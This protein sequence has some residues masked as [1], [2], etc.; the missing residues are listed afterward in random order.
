MRLS[1]E[2]PLSSAARAKQ[3]DYLAHGFASR[4]CPGREVNNCEYGCFASCKV[5]AR[6]LCRST[7]RDSTSVNGHF[8]FDV[9]CVYTVHLNLIY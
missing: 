4:P 5:G 2:F 8:F 6:T 9:Y 3:I 7:S 1:L